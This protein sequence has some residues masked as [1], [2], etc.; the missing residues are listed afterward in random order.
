ML[1]RNDFAALKAENERMAAEVVKLEQ[2]VREDINRVMAGNRLDL[3]LEKG[4][5]WDEQSQLAAELRETEA[6][7]EQEMGQLRASLQQVK[8]DTLRTLLTTASTLGLV[9]LGYMRLFK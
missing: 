4:K 7:I 2:K 1:E 5:L 6:K 8:F 9:A 3:N